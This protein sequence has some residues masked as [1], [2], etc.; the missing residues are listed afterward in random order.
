M[1]GTDLA[2]CARHDKW[3]DA[4]Q[5]CPDCL[6]ADEESARVRVSIIETRQALRRRFVKAYFQIGWQQ[7]SESA[8][9]AVLKV[10]HEM[11]MHE[12]LPVGVLNARRLR[13]FVEAFE[14]LAGIA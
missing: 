11:Q 9:K 12:G 8:E 6:A 7:S 5:A 2:L 3:S 1:A 14:S 4:G 13:V 10:K